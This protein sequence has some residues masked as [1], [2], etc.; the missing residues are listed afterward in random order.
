[1]QVS[2]LGQDR[3]SADRGQSVD[4]TDQVGQL[5]LAKD[6][7]HSVLN[8]ILVVAGSFPVGQDPADPLQRSLAVLEHASGG[9]DSREDLTD[10]PQARLGP[11]RAGSPRL[12]PA[13]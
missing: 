12:A 11:S 13:G 2:G 9:G 10:D 6:G 4:G 5:E 3:G 1:V 7:D 8:E